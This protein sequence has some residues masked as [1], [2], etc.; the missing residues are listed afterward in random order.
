[1]LEIHQYVN[2]FFEK[3]R[4]YGG[5]SMDQVREEGWKSFYKGLVDLFVVAP[6]DFDL[7]LAPEAF[8][9]N[10]SIAAGAGVNSNLKTVGDYNEI[11][12]HPIIKLGNQ[13]YFIPVSFSVF[14]A[15]YESPF[16][17]MI[18]DES[19]RELAGQRRGK[20]GE[21]ITYNF[22][23]KVFGAE[24]TFKSVKIRSLQTE[25]STKS[26]DDKTDIDVLCVLG[27]KALCVQVKSKKLTE[28]AKKG[29]DEALGRDFKAAVQ[30]AYDQGKLSRIEVLSREAQ[31]IDEFGNEIV[32]SESID[33]VY[34]MGVTTENYPSLT[35][36][37]STLLSKDVEDPFPL[38]LTLFDLE[39]LS[40]YLA[41]P[42]DF[43]YYV[44]QR[45]DLMEYFKA[46]EE[47]VFLGY[48]LIHKLW[49]IPKSDRSVLDNDF[50][51][52]IDRNYY[53][54]KLGLEIPNDGDQIASRWKNDD[55]ERLCDR[56][57]SLSEPKV[58]DIIFH[59]YDWSGDARDALLKYLLKAKKQALADGK[60]HNFSMPPS[61]RDPSQIGVT[62][63]VIASNSY[64]EL[65]EKLTVLV[66]LRKYKSKG[67]AWIGIGS[68]K[69][70]PE[71]V[72]AIFFDEAPWEYD[73]DL[74]R[75]SSELLEGAGGGRLIRLGEKV[76]RNERCLCGSMQ[77]YKR[78]CGE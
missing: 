46:D 19:Y 34:I 12:S 27:S 48:H 24:R 28:L 66:R 6:T 3:S 72:D 65:R 78:C 47:I 18:K 9:D 41:D 58:T 44:R 25:K 70:S 42:Y 74:E 57:K 61:E 38:F 1:M 5:N 11:S 77:K 45:V 56:I 35:H 32:L 75:L 8:F 60:R 52:L 2:L 17:W 15:V 4:G 30:D 53:P 63:F 49:R 62:Y 10:F 33:E 59:L 22:L 36:Q 54:Y 13:K 26:R 29:N 71:I 64:Y 51:Q 73:E 55:F 40:H 23:K 21:Q 43:L 39:L 69:D 37:A 67:K 50:G 16:Y 7:E 20:A 31:F 76:G 68:L 14:E